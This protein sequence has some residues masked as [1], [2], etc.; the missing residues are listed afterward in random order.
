[1]AV[2]S[3]NSAI[4][5]DQYERIVCDWD[6]VIQLFD[7]AVIKHMREIEHKYNSVIDLSAFTKENA[8]AN[9]LLRNKYNYTDHIEG[10]ELKQFFYKVIFK[11]AIDK[12]EFYK[13]SMFL[14]IAQAL[15]ILT[16]NTTCKNITFLSHIIPPFTNLTISKQNS[17][18]YFQK[19]C[20]NPNKVNLVLTDGSE[21]SKAEWIKLNAPDYT[22]FID[23]RADTIKDVILNTNSLHK[24]FLLPIYGYNVDY[25]KEFSE[26]SK[27]YQ[28]DITYYSLGNEDLENSSI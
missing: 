23:D 28:C 4:P 18:E 5:L 15:Q 13:S 12:K 10:E 1:M 9:L 6:G 25:Q 26:L 7:D 3:P 24:T 19:E 27:E 11:E 8:L 16:G 14:P 22:T 17:F 2:I 21:I 20:K